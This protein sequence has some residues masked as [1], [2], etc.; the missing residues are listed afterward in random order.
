MFFRCP[1]QYYMRYIEGLKIAP[2]G[3]MTR[4]LVCHSTLLINKDKAEDGLLSA[5]KKG[6]D[7]CLDE[8]V[9]A[10]NTLLDSKKDEV[11]WSDDL[12]F[13]EVRNTGQDAVKCYHKFSKRIDKI[14]EVEAKIDIDIDGTKVIGYIDLVTEAYNADLKIKKR[15]M[16]LSIAEMMQMGIYNMYNDKQYCN[17]HNV[18]IRKKGCEVIEYNIP[19]KN[20]PNDR[21]RQYLET[22]LAMKEKEMYPP[23]HPDNWSCSPNFCGYYRQCVYAQGKRGK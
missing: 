10:Y 9:D 3:A 21:I 6:N 17:L 22:F 18:I 5:K 1:Y 11:E 8:T 12:P 7:W 2:D 14:E 23:C 16:D 20:L 13:E 4:G 15:K 19:R